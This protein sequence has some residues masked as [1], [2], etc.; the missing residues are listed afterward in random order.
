MERESTW[1][2]H[3]CGAGQP[4]R[5]HELGWRSGGGADDWGEEDEY[6]PR[7]ARRGGPATGFTTRD[8]FKLDPALVPLRHIQRTEI[9]L[10][11]W[12]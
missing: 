6:A 8:H 4:T 2:A 10:D 5:W 11:T 3:P 1:P 7:I 12:K 9:K